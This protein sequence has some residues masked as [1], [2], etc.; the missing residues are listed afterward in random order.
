MC[1]R[2]KILRSFFSRS[3]V[4]SHG[5]FFEPVPMQF[6]YPEKN[7]ALKSQ[8]SSSGDGSLPLRS[9][10]RRGCY[11]VGQVRRKLLRWQLAGK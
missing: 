1:H 5:Q 9:D 2:E 7:L 8:A 3:L 11:G 4:Y 6:L 10:T